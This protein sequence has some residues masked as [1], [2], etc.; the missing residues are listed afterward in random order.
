MK[1]IFNLKKTSFKIVS[2][3]LLMLTLIACETFELEL[4]DTPNSLTSAS[5]DPDLFLSSIQISTGD[6]FESVTEEGMEVTRILHMFGPLYRNAYN[7][8]QLNTPWSTAYAT[9]FADI[10]TMLPLTDALGWSTHSG[11]AKLLKSYVGLTLVDFLG[12]VPIYNAAQGTAGL[13]PSLVGGAIVYEEILALIQEARNDLS[14]SPAP[15][16]PSKDFFYGGDRSK[17]IKFAN[18]LELKL[19]IQ[20]KLVADPS[21]AAA[22]NSLISAGNL[23]TTKA[24]DFQFKYSTTQS[25][26]DSRHPVF[27]DNYNAA[28]DVADYMSNSYMAE[29]TGKT[30]VDPRA[31]YYFYRQ[32]DDASSGDENEMPCSSEDRPSHYAPTDVF[33]YIGY[34]NSNVSSIGYWGRDHGDNDGIPPDGGLRTSFGLYPVGG[35]FDDGSATSVTGRS[36]GLAGAGISPIFLSS[37]THFMI[38]EWQT[39]QGID[40]RATL[41]AGIRLSLDKVINFASDSGNPAAA[42]DAPDFTSDIETYVEHVCGASNAASLWATSTDRMDLIVKEYFIALFGNGV[43]AYNTYRRTGKPANLQQTLNPIPGEYINSFYYP[44]NEVNNNSNVEQK[45]THYESVFWAVGGPT[46]N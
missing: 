12:A 40:A 14:V 45:A 43:E 30:V 36:D 1:K 15:K 20:R 11:I 34:L 25:N 4:V 46:V 28:A 21:D 19:R 31:L 2:S 41:E 23:I 29:V 26:P 6:F 17:W 10:E 5:A 3:C 32:S 37:F 42:A 18:T 38:A 13:E 33:C 44:R 8:T 24:D 22:I 27:A 16:S 9:I 35:K 7:S 39:Q